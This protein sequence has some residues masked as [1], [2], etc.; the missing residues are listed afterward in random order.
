MNPQEKDNSRRS[1]RRTEESRR[2]EK[3]RRTPQGKDRQAVAVGQRGQNRRGG[4]PAAAVRVR[5]SG[6][7]AAGRIGEKD[8]DKELAAAGD[9]EGG[10]HKPLAAKDDPLFKDMNSKS[11]GHQATMVPPAKST[12]D[13]AAR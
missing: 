1:T 7:D 2:R 10:K 6:G 5:R 4:H 11:F 8:K 9:H 12:L 3:P 13:V